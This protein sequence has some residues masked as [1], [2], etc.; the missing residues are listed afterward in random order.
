MQLIK[1]TWAS[2]KSNIVKVSGNF[3]LYASFIFGFFCAFCLKEKNKTNVNNN[4]SKPNLALLN[5]ANH[6]NSYSDEQK[7]IKIKCK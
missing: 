2:N 4:I 5:L 6:L 1:M 3:R 7:Y